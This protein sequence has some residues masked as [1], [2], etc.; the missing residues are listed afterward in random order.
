[1]SEKTEAQLRIEAL[2]KKRADRRAKAQADEDTRRAVDL[3]TIDA[4]EETHGPE[5]V[6]VLDV[7]FVSA[8]LAVKLA[9][10]CPDGPE[11]E[12]YKSRVKDKGT[13]GE[14]GYRRGDHAAA[15]EELASSTLLYPSAE[16][17]ARLC[18]FYPG[19]PVQGGRC[20]ADLAMGDE[21]AQGKG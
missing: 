3:E 7:P 10:R 5:R 21:D 18:S 1:M 2:E 8:D 4:L 11:W 15:A 16:D 17:Y 13:P 20:A 6:A 9:F 19:I 14:K 12:R